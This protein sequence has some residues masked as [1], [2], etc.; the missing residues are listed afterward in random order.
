MR[1]IAFRGLLIRHLI[2][3]GG[4]EDTKEALDFVKNNLSPEILVNH[5]NQYYPTHL[6]YKYDELNR[7]LTFIF[8]HFVYIIYKAEK[9]IQES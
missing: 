7:R 5:M 1:G 9:Y 3:P 2:L 4:L 8:S 6:A